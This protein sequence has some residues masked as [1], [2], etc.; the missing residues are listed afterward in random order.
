M[1]GPMTESGH[2]AGSTLEAIGDTPLIEV[3]GIWARL[4]SPNPS[5]L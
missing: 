3:G 5:G 4:E 2:Y 1:T